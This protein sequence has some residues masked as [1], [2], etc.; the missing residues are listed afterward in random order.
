MNERIEQLAEQAG[1]IWRG[2]Y[3]EHSNGDL[4]YTERK[5]VDPVDMDLEQFVGL[6]VSEC[7]QVGEDTDGNSNVKS[8]ILKHFGFKK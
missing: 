6:I 8:E 5:S 1:G 4:V 2:G 3:V 7:A